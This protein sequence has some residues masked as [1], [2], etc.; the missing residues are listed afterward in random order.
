[1]IEYMIITKFL[2]SFNE[3][4]VALIPRQRAQVNEFMQ[5]GILTSYS[6][7]A[8]RSTLWMTILATSEEAVEKT[9]RMMPLFHFMQ[10]RITELMF[11]SSPTY[12]VPQF[13][14]N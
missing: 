1:M 7:S 5:K 9:L 10:Y 12:A 13:S 4:F 2:S 3:E 14:L 6:L 8:D 11:H